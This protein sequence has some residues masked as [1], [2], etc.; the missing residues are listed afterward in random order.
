MVNLRNEMIR[1]YIM[2][3]ENRKVYKIL[4]GKPEGKRLLGI[5]R[6]RWVDNIKMDLRM[7]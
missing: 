1:A 2:N 6:H 5:R 4:V 3:W 7:A